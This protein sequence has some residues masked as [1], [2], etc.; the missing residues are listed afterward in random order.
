MSVTLDLPQSGQSAP[1]SV[2]LSGKLTR[3]DYQ[4]FVPPLENYMK[5]HGKIRMLVRLAD[6]H[7]WDAGALWEDIK[8]DM[9]HFSEL[10]RLAMVGDSKWEK[11]MASFCKPFT[12]AK[13]RYFDSSH[14]NEANAWIRAEAKAPAA[15]A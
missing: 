15:G 1:V 5:E 3:S 8:F 10:E 12:T 11:W 2:T 4:E 13:I 6:F 14:E 7:G 9:K